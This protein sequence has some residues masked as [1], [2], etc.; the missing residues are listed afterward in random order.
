MNLVIDVGNTL[1]KA[2]L[3]KNKELYALWKG[4]QLDEKALS[5]FIGDEQVKAA[6]VSS[7]RSD[8][9][10]ETSGLDFIEKMDFPVIQA[11]PH[12]KIPLKILYETPETLGSDRL[13]AALGGYALYP[14]EN[15]LVFNAGT[16]LTSDF[17]NSSGEYLGGTISP[18]LRMR[19]RSLHDYTGKLPEIDLPLAPSQKWLTEMNPLPGKTTHESILS[20]VI[21]GMIFEIDG[22]VESWQKKIRFFN[23]ILSGGDGIF[24]DKKLKNRIFALDNIVLYGLNVM[25]QHNV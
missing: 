13:A 23:V 17:V 10:S 19:L 11:G 8:G 3:F 21:H 5:A 16:C 4:T 7:V 14:G 20:G 12:L 1:T 24:F 25:L 6:I 9:E 2:A 22:L 18:G 15:V